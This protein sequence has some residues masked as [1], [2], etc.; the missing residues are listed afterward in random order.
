MNG[1]LN[2]EGRQIRMHVE[3]GEPLWVAKD[4][5]DVLGI[6][7]H[8]DALARLDDDEKGGPLI[9]DTL[10]GRQE[11]ASINESGLYSLILRSRK[12]EAK[13]FRR[14]VTKEVLPSIRRSGSYGTPALE[15]LG[16]L[17]PT[18]VVRSLVNLD[19][20]LARLERV[21]RPAVSVTVDPKGS[22]RIRQTVSALPHRS[23]GRPGLIGEEVRIWLRAFL[24]NGPRS[25]YECLMAGFDLGFTRATIDRA[26]RALGAS[27]RMNRGKEAYWMLPT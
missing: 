18:Q 10:G 3:D 21:G 26:A 27:S 8:H 11:V 9:V 23:T 16:G 4:V 7:K 22:V 1:I 12:P 20:R 5:C 14:W 15:S 17:S 24:A 13:A 19:A 6:Q 25:R 2:F